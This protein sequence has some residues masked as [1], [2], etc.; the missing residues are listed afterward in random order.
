MRP[1]IVKINI[2]GPD[3]R[4]STVTPAV[5]TK[6]GQVMLTHSDTDKWRGERFHRGRLHDERYLMKGVGKI[7]SG[8]G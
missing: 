6:L 1:T 8:K 2:N 3:S 4:N 5:Q 7:K